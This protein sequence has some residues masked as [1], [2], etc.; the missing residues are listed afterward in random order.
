MDE[1]RSGTPES[2]AKSCATEQDLHYNAIEECFNSAHGVELLQQAA[3]VFNYWLPGSTTIPHTFVNT[4]DV[5]PSYTA[6]KSALCKAGSEATVCASLV[7]AGATT[8]CTV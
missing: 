7:E 3:D 4:D 6:L 2:C 8:T 5:N 1:K